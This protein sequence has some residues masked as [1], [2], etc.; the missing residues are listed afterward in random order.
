MKKIKLLISVIFIVLSINL[1][2]QSSFQKYKEENTGKVTAWASGICLSSKKTCQFCGEK[3][4]FSYNKGYC[5]DTCRNKGRKKII[6]EYEKNK[7]EKDE[8][9]KQNKI[10][11]TDYYNSTNPSLE[12]KLMFFDSRSIEFPFPKKAHLFPQF[13]N[14]NYYL[15]IEDVNELSSEKIYLENYYESSIFLYIALND[16]SEIITLITKSGND[17]DKEL[18]FKIPSSSLLK[19]SSAQNIEIAFSNKQLS[20]FEDFYFSYTYSELDGF[21]EFVEGMKLVPKK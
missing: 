20:K 1:S 18:K 6:D 11:F 4:R 15:I 7:K 8:L 2:G 5:S 19:I 21:R 3:Y 12:K 9:L 14:S 17:S 10:S 16:R 13:S